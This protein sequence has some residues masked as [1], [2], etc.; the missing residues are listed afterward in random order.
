MARSTRGGVNATG[1]TGSSGFSADQSDGFFDAIGD[2]FRYQGSS[3]A[4]K[5]VYDEHG[6]FLD[7]KLQA[8]ALRDYEQYRKNPFA[9]PSARYQKLKNEADEIQRRAATNIREQITRA[10]IGGQIAKEDAVDIARGVQQEA[11]EA[12][13]QYT[14][15]LGELEAEDTRYRGRRAEARAY[16]AEQM[17]VDGNVFGSAANEAFEKFIGIGLGSLLDDALL[18]TKKPATTVSGMVPQATPPGALG[19]MSAY[20]SDN[21]FGLTQT[22]TFDAFNVDAS[23]LDPY[24]AGTRDYLLGPK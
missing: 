7:E 15:Q 11:G 4:E 18:S 22:P 10:G 17:D 16:G 8:D 23:G 20:G 9:N 3:P 14:G 13:A 6:L 24:L 12:A 21:P 19:D 5:E 2:Y 1:T